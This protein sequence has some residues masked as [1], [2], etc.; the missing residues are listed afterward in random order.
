[1]PDWLLS[2]P[3]F[4]VAIGV[5]V[6]VHEYGHF[7]VAR[8]M[9]VKVLRFSVGFGKPLVRFRRKNDPTEYVI[10]ALP[11][12]GYVKMLD[13]REGEVPAAERD[14]AFNNKSVWARIAVV[15]A[16]PAAN[17]LLAMVLFA[18]VYMLGITGLRPYAGELESGSVAETAGFQLRDEI[19]HVA[20][21]PTRTWQEVRLKM[22]EALVDKKDFDIRVST[23][24]GRPA[25]R[26]VPSGAK[27]VLKQDG[28]VIENL[29]IKPWW[30]PMEP[31]V[32]EVVAA[33]PAEAAGLK[34]GDRIVRMNGKAIDSLDMWAEQ[35]RAH[36]GKAIDIQIV[37]DG[38]EQTL[39]L[40]P[41]RKQV[42]EETIGFAGVAVNVPPEVYEK[43]RVTVRYPVHVALAKGGGK[44]WD[45]TL[46]TFD[47]I[48]ELLT[49][50][51]SVK[52]IS[53]PITI[54]EYAG[55]SAS[56]DM[57]YYLHFIAFISISLAVL[58]ILPVPLLDGGHLLYYLIELVKGSPVSETV[59]AIGQR[60][61]IVLIASLI[62]L[63]FYNDIT[64]LL[65]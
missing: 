15:C 63:A 57:S 4:I 52:N 30:P 5:L 31:V 16:G 42:E 27:A 64:R 28:D 48:G 53:G 8:R 35:I 6:A 3:A 19:T 54:A 61:G 34:A 26:T 12:G 13:E 7:W 60:V 49:G 10:A 9:G 50:G 44:T 20:G 17:V 51:A 41:R 29:G 45:M 11:L 21:Q 23:A 65:E 46:L 38:R 36:P 40:T 56:V 14:R 24:D 47:M 33:S 59:E 43:M 55:R 22:L 18:A 62:M 2:V 32:V 58:N 39:S 37:R 25:I 1:M